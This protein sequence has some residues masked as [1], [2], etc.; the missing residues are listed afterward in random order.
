[1]QTSP[2]ESAPA[3]QVASKSSP[4]II[5]WGGSSLQKRPEIEYRLP[6]LLA[7]SLAANGFEREV[8]DWSRDGLVL[9]GFAERLAPMQDSLIAEKPEWVILVFGQEECW[10]QDLPIQGFSESLTAIMQ[11]FQQ[12]GVNTMIITP[13]LPAPTAPDWVRKRGEEICRAI[14]AAA[15]EHYSTVVDFW[16]FCEIYETQSGNRPEDLLLDDRH[17]NEA[18]HQFMVQELTAL[19]VYKLGTE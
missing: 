2:S 4:R 7:N 13:N 9:D 8:V 17:P 18:A 19:L 10:Q 12:K 6:D 1:S 3:T 14:R 11:G 5:V 16:N 15:I